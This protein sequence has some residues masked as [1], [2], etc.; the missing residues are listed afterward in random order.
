MK[1]QLESALARVEA[2]RS[3][4][5]NLLKEF[6]RIP[7][8][9]TD[10][11][12]EKDIK[13][14]ADWVANQLRQLNFENIRIYETPRHPVVYGD[15]LHAGPGKPTIL[16]YGHYDVQPPEPLELWDSPPF[17]PTQ[18]GE[19]LFGRGASDMKGQIVIG[20]KALEAMIENNNL[21]I[22]V[23]FIIEGE[24]EIGSPNLEEFLNRQ[25]DLLKCDFAVNLDGGMI[26]PDLPTITYGLRGLAYFELRVTGPNHDL[27]SGIYGGVVHNPAQ[28]ICELIAG[29]HDE[30][31]IVTLPGFYDKVHPLTPN[32][33]AE[34]ARLPMDD[35]FYI[36]QTG[37]T[38]L[39]GEDGYTPIERI[40]ARPTLEVN[41]LLSGFT[42][43]GSKTV[44]PAGAMAKISMRLVPDQDPDEVEGQLR[45][46]L[47]VNA[48]RTVHWEVENLAGSR[49]SVMDKNLPGVKALAQAMEA[50]WGKKP[51]YRREGG[52]VPVVTFMK[53]ILNLDSVLTGFGLPDDNLHG[54]NEKI[55]LP[56]FFNGIE[57]IIRYIDILGSLELHQSSPEAVDL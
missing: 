14:A 45:Q 23:K 36:A 18:R 37:V 6:I 55:H 12:A 35:H 33:K 52:S 20:L 8:I 24:E 44:L 19:N 22:N 42:G 40:G 3:A 51:V 30:S 5:I 27:H 25:R 11:S 47:Q 57:T 50:T 10:P 49:A 53:E 46:Y 31:G 17:V 16:F 48:P 41:G 39:Y 28:V 29:M 26:G 32:E 54:P 4:T 7:S 9:S 13:H 21:P 43:V 1:S 34:L 2:E 38:E 15:W 56:T